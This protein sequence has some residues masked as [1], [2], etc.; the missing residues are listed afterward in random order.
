MIKQLIFITIILVLNQSFAAAQKAE[1]KKPFPVTFTDIA[2]KAGI[3]DTNF[4]GGV[5]SKTYIIETNGCGVAFFDYDN[6]GWMDVFVMNG[7]RLEGFPKGK[8]PTTHLYRNNKN[9][10]FTDVTKKAGLERTG[11]GSGVTIGDYDNDGFEDIF[12]TYYG[13]NVLYHN[14][15]NGTVC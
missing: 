15:G 11:W 4:Y 9:R 7:T 6:D 5:D 12:L 1:E 10:T 14:K 8:E 3:R 2:Q 13:Q